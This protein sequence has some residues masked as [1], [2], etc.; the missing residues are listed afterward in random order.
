MTLTL[1]EISIILLE[2]LQEFH[3]KEPSASGIGFEKFLVLDEFKAHQTKLKDAALLLEEDGFAKCFMTNGPDIYAIGI[4]SRGKQRLEERKNNQTKP[5]EIQ[6]LIKDL[7]DESNPDRPRDMEIPKT[8]SFYNKVNDFSDVNGKIEFL[9]KVLMGIEEFLIKKWSKGQKPGNYING[10]PVEYWKKQVKQYSLYIKIR[11]M[12]EKLVDDP[13][14]IFPN[15]YKDILNIYK[16][17]EKLQ[18]KQTMERKKYWENHLFIDV[19]EIKDYLKEL[20][21]IE[22]MEFLDYHLHELNQICY[23]YPD[24][25]I[26]IVLKKHGLQD[27]F[28]RIKYSP[29]ADFEHSHISRSEYESFLRLLS[30]NIL[31]LLHTEK[32]RLKTNVDNVE[33]K[34]EPENYILQTP[35]KDMNTKA[36]N[37][38]VWKGSIADLKELFQ[39]LKLGGLIEEITQPNAV[40]RDCFVKPDGTDFK[41][42]TV[43]KTNIK[44]KSKNYD[45]I[46]VSVENVKKGK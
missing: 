15:H 32:R 35:E 29:M 20:N 5:S 18:N 27:K 4:T 1:R 23:H 2:K 13:R 36:K 12:I 26:E 3:E 41:D 6:L 19:I 8:N 30:K 42:E 40:I 37:R 46:K 11:R 28:K 45:K 34:N 9:E 39:E 22:K 17:L 44:G 33:M 14:Y 25:A 21:D 10:F 38:I 24:D 31:P 7:I 16:D 43:R